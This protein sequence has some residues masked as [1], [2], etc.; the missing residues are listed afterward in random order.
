MLEAK[1]V[2]GLLHMAE[3]DAVEV[4]VAAASAL[5]HLPLDQSAW[6]ALGP[7]VGQLLDTTVAGS[8]ERLQVIEVAARVPL[9]SVREGMI[10]IADD[11]SESDG[12][13]VRRLLGRP[14][15]GDAAALLEIVKNGDLAALERLACMP[16]ERLG[17]DSRLLRIPLASR[18]RRWSQRKGRGTQATADDRLWAALALARLG[19]TAPLDAVLDTLH[20]DP[21]T[22]FWGSPWVAYDR[23]AAMRPV[24]PSLRDHLLARLEQAGATEDS[25]GRMSTGSAEREAELVM[26]AVT[27]VADAEGF[28]IDGAETTGSEPEPASGRGEGAA[29][30][31]DVDE[32]DIQALVARIGAGALDATSS[33][34]P[35]DPLLARLSP[36]AAGRVLGAALHHIAA[37]G[38]EVDVQHGAD[39][40]I[41]G[42]RL[43]RLAM[44]LS[45][46]LLPLAALVHRDLPSI[47]TIVDDGQVAYVLS[48]AGSGPVC[49]AFQEQLRDVTDPQQKLRVLQFIEL[50]ADYEQD[51]LSLPMLGGGPDETQPIEVA[52]ELIDDTIPYL[53]Q[54]QLEAAPPESSKPESKPP[55]PWLGLP[56]P[57]PRKRTAWPHVFC[58]DAVVIGVP[59]PLEVGL[60]QMEDM[61][62]EGT[63]AFTVPVGAFTLQVEL[64]LQGFAVV[65]GDLGFTVEVTPDEPY[66]VTTV[67][68]VAFAN[69][70]LT[71]ERRIGVTFRI[72]GE[73]RGYAAR[74][75]VVTRSAE[76]AA[77][78]VPAEPAPSSIDASPFDPDQ[79]ADLN[80]VIRRGDDA[81]PTK[82]TTL[83]WS[84]GSHL[85]ALDTPK[86]TPESKIGSTPDAFLAGIVAKASS[87]PSAINLFSWLE[88]HGR[89]D[90]ATKIPA[91]VQKAILAVTEAVKPRPPTILLVTEDPYM[92]WELAVLEPL[93]TPPG[94]SPFLG[95]HAA[96]GRWT[97]SVTEPPPTRP[98]TTVTVREAA[99]ISGVYDG[100]PGFKRLTSAEQEAETLLKRWA[101]AHPV[102]ASF[103]DVLDCIRGTP[104][105]DIL[106]FAIHGRVQPG[107]LQ[108]GLVLI[109]HPANKPHLNIAEFM[110]PA[111]IASGHLSR[112]P[113]VFLNACQ[114]GAGRQVLGNY[115]GM[116]RSFLFAGAAAVVAPLWSINDEVASTIALDF[117][118]GALGDGAATP[119]E[120][121]RAQRAAV[122]EEAIKKGGSTSTTPL[123]YLFFGHPK[124]QL[125]RPP[126]S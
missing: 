20:D 125:L 55:G 84:V 17:V 33:S 101:G 106:H 10:R 67:Q 119:A 41:I 30:P 6:R 59:F 102:S 54:P 52:T 117:Y 34:G 2:T 29:A 16:I 109:G 80:I 22:L 13:L 103:L 78:V 123:A 97:L 122:T 53:P 39:R 37:H 108:D 120:L 89:A 71:K 81:D 24:P 115:S 72:Q 90:I 66:P 126:N 99:V 79:A 76:E 98:P 28:A 1:D 43:V 107:G 42:N 73:M 85:V 111:H 4:R 65:E 110:E 75:V 88:G 58:N 77:V 15:P 26:W 14:S 113:L 40:L 74:N 27:G 86:E 49:Q 47:R 3:D 69:P 32:Q 18:T 8:P 87:T 48:R 9:L 60:R 93:P 38:D 114:V 105:A 63:G 61:R 64:S 36:Q 12:R 31:T 46:P 112:A 116:A 56:S 118:A 94:T 70:H 50:V 68:L 121:L 95:A 51:R 7:V 23:L 44:Q 82:S 92:P 96:I 104:P 25:S 57:A 124:L 100:V 35:E 19:E 62:L 83:L 45:T 91:A 21:P 11:D 5:A